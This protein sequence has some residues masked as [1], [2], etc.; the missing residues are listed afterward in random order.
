MT[1]KTF[2]LKVYI[3]QPSI[4]IGCP[5]LMAAIEPQISAANKTV[6]KRVISHF[7]TCFAVIVEQIAAVVKGIMWLSKSGFYSPIDF[8]G[9]MFPRKVAM[10][11]SGMLQ[12]SYVPVEKHPNFDH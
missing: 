11:I 5:R 8:A 9:P 4:N 2:Q 3:G 7:I 12:P 6:V 10:R 1:F